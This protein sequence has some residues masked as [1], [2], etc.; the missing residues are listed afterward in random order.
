[1]EYWRCSVVLTTLRP[2]GPESSNS[3]GGN[4]VFRPLFFCEFACESV[5]VNN[6]IYQI[7]AFYVYIATHLFVYFFKFSSFEFHMLILQICCLIIK[8]RINV[9]FKMLLGWQFRKI[10]LNF[11]RLTTMSSVVRKLIVLLIMHP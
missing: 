9:N 3:R 1:M 2:N 10:S 7:E 6:L 11:S 5:N 4:V 8:S